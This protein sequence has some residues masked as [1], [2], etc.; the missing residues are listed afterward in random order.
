MVARWNNYSISRRKGR[1]FGSVLGREYGT[2]VALLLRL[3]SDS[4]RMVARRETC[5][6]PVIRCLNAQCAGRS[7]RC[8]NRA[9]T[10]FPIPLFLY[11][12]PAGNKTA[13]GYIRPHNITWSSDSRYI[14]VP[15]NSTTVEIWDV[16]KRSLAS[17]YRRPHRYRLC[18][19]MVSRWYPY[20]LS[21]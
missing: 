4:C 20:R 10:S 11:P 9:G 15:N 7:K 8:Y 2:T 13:F 14:A 18:R 21:Q 16:T 17:T 12:H 1:S 6:Y 5:R 19:R 3:A